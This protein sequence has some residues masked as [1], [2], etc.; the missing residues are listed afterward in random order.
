M[1]RGG[2]KKAKHFKEK[3]S[4]KRVKKRLQTR[5]K[6]IQNNKEN[7]EGK[8]ESWAIQEGGDDYP[9]SLSATNTWTWTRLRWAD[10]TQHNST[11]HSPYTVEREGEGEMS[12]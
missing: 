7:N 10:T 8:Q 5:Q 12:E 3:M 1:Y 6:S 11:T 2:G 9:E 4:E